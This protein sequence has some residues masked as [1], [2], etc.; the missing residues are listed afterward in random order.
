MNKLED[1]KDL[2]DAMIAQAIAKSENEAI[3]Q[4]GKHLCSCKQ[5]MRIKAVA[6]RRRKPNYYWVATMFCDKCQQV[7]TLIFKLTDLKWQVP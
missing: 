1:S 5:V 3:L 6:L 2:T 7:D 4:L